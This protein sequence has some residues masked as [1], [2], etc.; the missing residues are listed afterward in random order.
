MNLLLYT[1]YLLYNTITV[2]YNITL[3]FHFVFTIGTS[4][5]HLNVLIDLCDFRSLLNFSTS[6][7]ASPL[8]LILIAQFTF[9]HNRNPFSVGPK[10]CIYIYICIYAKVHNIITYATCRRNNIIIKVGGGR[11]R[12]RQATD[13]LT[14][15]SPG[16]R[17]SPPLRPSGGY[18]RPRVYVRN[19]RNVIINLRTAT[20]AA[21]AGSAR[22]PFVGTHAGRCAHDTSPSRSVGS[23]SQ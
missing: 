11:R 2:S 13:V 3:V 10:C 20:A 15:V 16:R 5:V 7:Q 22:T 23:C 21:L 18:R 17:H 1:R 4:L 12:A 8:I 14:D 9:E 6:L 19:V